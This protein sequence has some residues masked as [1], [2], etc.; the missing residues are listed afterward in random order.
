MINIAL[1]TEYSFKKCFGHIAETVEGCK[2]SALGIADE[3]ST[4]GHIQFSKRCIA[5]GIKP[6][7]GVRLRA[8][9]AEKQRTGQ[10]YWIFLARNDAGLKEIYGLVDKAYAGFFF[11]PRLT[12]QQISAISHDVVVIAPTV[13]WDMKIFSHIEAMDRADYLIDSPF[14]PSDKINSVAI[15]ENFYPKEEDKPIYELLAGAQK[16]A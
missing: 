14:N 15:Q 4:Y 10:Q 16:R 5:E 7:F 8:P 3:D 13:E 6:I 1:R 9:I 2:E 12:I 11:F